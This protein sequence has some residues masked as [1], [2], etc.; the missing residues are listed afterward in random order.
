MDS[1]VLFSMFGYI[2]FM[3]LSVIIYRVKATT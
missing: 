1:T 2:T 3:I